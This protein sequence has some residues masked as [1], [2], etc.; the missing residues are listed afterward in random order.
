[1]TNSI[2]VVIAGASGVGKTTLVERIGQMSFASEGTLSVARRLVTREQRP[3]ESHSESDFVS[4]RELGWLQ[5][6]GAVRFIWSREMSDRTEY[7]GFHIPDETD[8]VIYPSNDA[9][10][11]HL[12]R[13][14]R[15]IGAVSLLIVLTC[16]QDVRESRLMGRSPELWADK[17]QIQH[18]LA[19][20]KLPDVELNPVVL[21]SLDLEA[22]ATVVSALIERLLDAQGAES[23]MLARQVPNRG[24]PKSCNPKTAA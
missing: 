7:Y 14:E 15:L 12:A 4:K 6:T 20:A 22:T 11:P 10:I 19:T 9:I 8:I 17:P 21:P 1:M 24:R 5:C 13:F 2:N 3:G 23:V 16:P 18:R